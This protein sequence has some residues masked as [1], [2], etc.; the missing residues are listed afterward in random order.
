M[1]TSRRIQTHLHV[2]GHCF[3]INPKNPK[4][5][6]STATSMGLVH[7]IFSSVYME[8]LLGDLLSHLGR[9]GPPIKTVCECWTEFRNEVFL[10]GWC[11]HWQPKGGQFWSQGVVQQNPARLPNRLSLSRCSELPLYLCVPSTCHTGFVVCCK[12][13]QYN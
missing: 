1:Q 10:L 8:S 12:S 2:W 9:I 13:F 7:G 4:L 3:M 6:N 5:F 11:V